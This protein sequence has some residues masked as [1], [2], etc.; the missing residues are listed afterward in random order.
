V[1]GCGK[2]SYWSLK[3]TGEDSRLKRRAFLAELDSVSRSK[4]DLV[5]DLLP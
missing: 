1:V 5:N 4:L 2:R 3:E